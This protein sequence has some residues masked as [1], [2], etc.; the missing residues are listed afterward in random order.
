[1]W[2]LR[3]Q[4]EIDGRIGLILVT[5]AAGK[6]GLA[7]IRGLTA[8][9]A[10]VRGLIHHQKY[11]SK[12]QDAG[13]RE[14]LPGDLL[15]QDDLKTAFQGV[16]VVYHIPP[17]VH[18][19]EVEIGENVIEEALRA[20][21]K[22]FAYH[23]VLHPQ[24]EAMPHHW[25]KLRVE[26]LLISSGLPFTILQPTAYMQNITN[27]LDKIVLS[28]VYQVPYPVDTELCLLDLEDLAEAAARV[29]DGSSHHGAV[30]PLVGTGLISQVEI[31][32]VLSKLL[33]KKIQAKQISLEEWKR[34]VSESEMGSY[35]ISTLV[36]MFLY[37]QDHGF[38]GNSR[39]LSWLLERPP[40]SL[41][42]CFRREFRRKEN[43]G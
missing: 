27:Q 40:T 29:L 7:V 39:V 16:R 38:S 37:Y 6:T 20:G 9:G 12:V 14:I 19:R 8:N 33:G 5:G 36:K 2:L 31:A 13:A 1:L 24:I 17:N 18:P 30:Y 21:V 23:S 4:T 41:E 15:D 22:H 3:K 35:Q 25:L 43:P 26:E 11:R 34:Q 28:G 10:D 32:A 42:T